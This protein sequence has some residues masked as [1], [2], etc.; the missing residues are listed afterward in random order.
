MLKRI[1][2]LLRCATSVLDVRLDFDRFP[3]TNR[4]IREENGEEIKFN[5]NF[6]SRNLFPGFFKTLSEQSTDDY[7]KFR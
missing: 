4:C 6:F 2:P 5:E 7:A 1:G 3:S